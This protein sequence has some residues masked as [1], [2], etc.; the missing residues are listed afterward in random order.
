[1]SFFITFYVSDRFSGVRSAV[2]LAKQCVF[3]CVCVC[4]CVCGSWALNKFQLLG[5]LFAHRNSLK[6]K[7][8]KRKKNL[9]AGDVKERKDN[10]S[11]QTALCAVWGGGIVEDTSLTE[12]GGNERRRRM[13][14]IDKL[15]HSLQ[16]FTFDTLTVSRLSGQVRPVLAP[17]EAPDGQIEVAG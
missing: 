17:G 10:K 6:R 12:E 5:R 16:K 14:L 3:V 4:V 13:G 15:A 7:E 11:S 9:G 1:M 8:K 2:M